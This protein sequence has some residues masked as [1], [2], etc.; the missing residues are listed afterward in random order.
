MNTLF[1]P[2]RRA[3][4]CAALAAL[5]FGGMQALAAPDVATFKAL[6]HSPAEEA[7]LH[8]ALT[9]PPPPPP[10]APVRIQDVHLDAILYIAA[11]NWVI[12][13]NGRMVRNGDQDADVRILGVT[14]SSVR[15]TV[16]EPPTPARRYPAVV[17]RPLQSWLV[18]TGE[19]LDRADVESK[20]NL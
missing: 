3:G 11:D 18:N 1:S 5:V 14:P 7:R 9:T 6:F 15:L 13:V 12:W 2:L 17:L 4:Q 8:A 16:P 19:V 20:S 10:P